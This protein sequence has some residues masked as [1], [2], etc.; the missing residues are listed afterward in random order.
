MNAR[1][2]T[3]LLI[4]LLFSCGK[5]QGP[6]ERDFT[7]QRDIQDEELQRIAREARKEFP[8]FI[9]KLQRPGKGER[10]FRV[11]YPFAADEESG[12]RYEELWLGN[13]V[14]KDRTYYGEVSN[15]PFHIPDLNIGDRVSFY[16]DTITDWMYERDGAIAGGRS[17][18]Y[19]IEQTSELD[20]D[21]ALTEWLAKFPAGE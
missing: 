14:F 21:P 6:Q 16:G 19:L 4:V 2:L 1:T 11:K 18:K 15:Q 9:R 8:G 3:F 10:N 5:N 13:I 17:I 20:R 7:L 12:F